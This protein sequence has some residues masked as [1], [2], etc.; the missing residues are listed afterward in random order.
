MAKFIDSLSLRKWRPFTMWEAIAGKGVQRFVGLQ[1]G[2]LLMSSLISS[3]LLEVCHYVVLNPVRAKGV[4]VPERWRWSSCRATAGIERDHRCLTVDWVLGQF[5]SKKRAAEKRYREFV[6]DEMGGRRIWDDVKGQS[7]L[8]DGD[9]VTR[10][11]DYARGYEGVKEIPKI[12][13]YLSRP[14]LAEIF[15]V[16]RGEKRR[17]DRGIEETVKRWRYTAPW[18]ETWFLSRSCIPK[19]P[20]F[21]GRSAL[22]TSTFVSSIL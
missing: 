22:R 1:P 4:E 11:V 19:F 6:M 20:G 14:S 9:F 16:A 13:R 15:N 8:G 21:Q 10:F 7:I 12:Q 18:I 17:R 2:S 3:H 5:G